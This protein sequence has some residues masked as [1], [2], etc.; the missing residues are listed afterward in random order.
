MA[1][2]QRLANRLSGCFDVTS[3]GDQVVGILT[4]ELGLRSCSI[5]LVDSTGERI[6]NLSGASPTRTKTGRRSFRLGEGVAG[7]AALCGKTIRVNDTR[8]DV[9]FL[10]GAGSIRS[11]LCL[12]LFSGGRVIGLLNLSHPDPGFFSSEHESV[13]SI[14]ATMVGHLLTFARLQGELSGLNRSLEGKVEA[15]TRE[16]EASQRKL[17]QQEKLVSLGTLVAGVAHELNNRL[18]PLLA[19]SHVLAETPRSEEERRLVAAMASAAVGAKKIVEGLLRFARQDHPEMEL[20]HWNDVIAEVVDALGFRKDSGR[21]TVRTALDPALPPVL[22]DAQQMGQV[23]I[24]LMNNAFDAMGECGT[25]EIVSRGEN[26]HVDVE[27]SDTGPGIPAEALTKIFD[28]FFTTK[29]VGRGTGLGLSLCYGMVRA[30]RGEINVESRPGRT[31]FTVR[32]PRA[33]GHAVDNES[34]LPSSERSHV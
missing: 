20:M 14:L 13:F 34:G 29:E 27:V 19:Y 17:F 16:I 9:R 21:I 26:A 22:G 1:I 33:T 15:K 7:S 18:V 30:H 23:L 25:L 2:V 28:P 10:K 32:L 4:D 12:P 31:V 11:L 8:Q 5:M 24:N 6:V 3:I